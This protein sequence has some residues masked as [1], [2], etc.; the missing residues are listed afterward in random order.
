VT[1]HVARVTNIGTAA[2]AASALR[3]LAGDFAYLLFAVGI[4]RAETSLPVR[5]SAAAS[6]K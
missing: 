2:Q 1:L 5:T 6:R 3:P 4:L